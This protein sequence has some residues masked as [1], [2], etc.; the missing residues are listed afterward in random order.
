MVTVL[1]WDIDGT[2]LTTARAGIHAWEAALEEEFGA[3]VD[4]NELQT[5]GLTDVEIGARLASMHAAS[6]DP[7][8]VDRLIRRYEDHLPANLPRRTGRVLP[9][10]REILEQLRSRVDVRSILLTGN[11]RAGARAKLTHY[12]LAD[13]FEHGA[14]SDGTTDRPTIARN[15]LVLAR[16]QLGKIDADSVYVI[17]DTPHDV[18]CGHAI[19]ARV[20]AVATGGYSAEQLSAHGPW[21]VVDALPEPAVFLRKLGLAA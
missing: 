17:G 9:N 10:V 8:L 12:G 2:L 7:S 6:V 5:A 19:G 15:A 14:F 1:C 16:E 11:T 3:P 21:W 18:E 4:L 20:V 13:F